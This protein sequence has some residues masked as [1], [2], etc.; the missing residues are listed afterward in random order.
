MLLRHSFSYLFAR[1]LPGVINLLAMALYTRLLSP[2][3]YGR[4]ALVIAGVGLANVTLFQ[5][6]RLGML[7]FL[8]AYEK[9]QEVFLSTIVAGY[10]GL[11]VVSGL[12][13]VITLVFTSDSV[14]RGL[15]ILGIILLWIQAFFEINLELVR[16]QLKPGRY[17]LISTVKTTVALGIGGLLA[18]WGFGAWGL[19]IGLM[20]GMLISIFIQTGSWKRVRFHFIDNRI[21][22]ELLVYG[23]PLSA[24]FILGFVV[25][26]SDRFLLGLFLGADATGMYAAGYDITKQTLGIL[27]V[28]VN[29]AAYPL[30]IRALE[31]NGKEAARQQLSHNITLLLIIA[32]PCTAGFV[33][34]APNIV[35][36]F[37]GQT[38]RNTAVI[39]IPWVALG[40]L[41]A[42]IKAYY[43]DLSF[44]LGRHTIGQVWVTLA[45]AIVNV[46]LNLWW[47]PR[48]GIIG[49]AYSTAAAYAISLFLS[50]ILGRS[51]FAL[52]LPVWGAAKI[53]LATL[54]MAIALVP[55]INLR[56]VWM[57]A[58][59]VTWGALIFGVL[60]WIL[61]VGRIRGRVLKSLLKTQG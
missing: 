5:W 6:L 24:T 1:G 37:L 32:L 58:A 26:S 42:G 52:P 44:Q 4:Y 50:Y 45:A 48:F 33:L 28:I 36:V 23:L 56:G 10:I 47:I 21:F 46:V 20:A 27:M 11:I 14:L 16:I 15:V 34:L 41:L 55:I 57:L 17:G 31:Q 22:R 59:Q 19:L 8:P 38:F 60:L 25:S 9:R 51:I 43:F 53:A 13:G 12:V 49:A 61:N 3:D 54:G 18:F 7:R 39:L 35:L 2:D 40:S 29:L 30:A